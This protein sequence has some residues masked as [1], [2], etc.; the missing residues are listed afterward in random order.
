MQ[1][2]YLIIE[3]NPKAVESLKLFMSEYSDFVFVGNEDVAQKAILKIVREKPNLVFLDVELTEG[4]GFDLIKNLKNEISKLPQFIMITS[5]DHYAKEALNLD[6]LYF[7]SKPFDPDE[8]ALALNKFQKN[9]LNQSEKLNLKSIDGYHVISFNE[10]AFIMSEGNYIHIFKSNDTIITA[11]ITL[12]EIAGKLPDNFIKTH[13]SYIINRN[14]IEYFN[15][16]KKNIVLTFPSEIKYIK[17]VINKKGKNV[18][19]KKQDPIL[20]SLQN[21]NKLSLPLGKMYCDE[22]KKQIFNGI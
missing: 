2:K 9:Q 21:E 13:K 15:S 8:L 3:D 5:H 22:V 11:S 1:Y 12:N 10:L 18:N 7:L 19:D 17:T 6:A 14:F 4:N 16:T 20:K